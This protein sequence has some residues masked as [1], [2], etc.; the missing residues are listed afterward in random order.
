MDRINLIPDDLIL[1]WQDRL[2]AYVDRRF[3]VVLIWAVAVVVV[4]ES[5]LAFR[6]GLRLHRYS[7][8]AAKLETKQ[9][10][11]KAELESSKAYLAQLD[12]TEQ[13]L[14]QQLQRL[15]QQVT[16]LSAYRE[17]QGALSTTLQELKQTIPYGIWLTELEVSAQ[18]PARVGGGAFEERLVTQFMGN[19]KDNPRF[20]NV[21]FSFT[22][23]AKIGKTGIVAFEITCHAV[24]VPDGA[25]P[26]GS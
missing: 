26:A 3:V 11:L 6:E 17:R 24:P 15:T 18:G 16:F 5:G 9:A 8:Q 14:K 23:K 4:L 12:Q 21:A 19:L 7:T 2:L 1:T 25:S 13:Q 10:G 20:T 22:R